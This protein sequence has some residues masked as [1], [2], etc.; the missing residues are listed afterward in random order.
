MDIEDDVQ[1]MDAEKTMWPSKGKGKGKAVDHDDLDNLP[2]Y[3]TCILTRCGLFRTLKGRK[4]PTR[5]F[6]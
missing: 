5:N 3:G 2:W 4:V 1:M 6:G